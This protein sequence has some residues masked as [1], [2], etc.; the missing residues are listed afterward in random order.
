MICIILGMGMP[1]AAV[2]VLLATLISPALIELG[3]DPMA[4]HLFVLYFGMMSMTTPPVAIAAFAAASIARTSPM[5][6]AWITAKYAWSAYVI[7]FLFVFSP[8]MLFKGPVGGITLA[9]IGS[10][11]GIWLISCSILGF[12]NRELHGWE[13]LLALVAGILVGSVALPYDNALIFGTLGF[14]LGL[15]LWFAGRMRPAR[16]TLE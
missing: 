12:M 7:P 8:A 2:Y 1:T 11:G 6:T 10:V 16:Q 3:I 13:R 4:A 9:L 15:T 5:R 14:V